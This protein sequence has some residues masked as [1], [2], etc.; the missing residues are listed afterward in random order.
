MPLG[1]AVPHLRQKRTTMALILQNDAVDAGAQAT[2]GV[3]LV[4][5]RD[6]LR[7]CQQRNLDPRNGQFGGAQRRETWVA[8]SSGLGVGADIGGERL[9]RLQ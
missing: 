9:P 7:C 3:I 1:Q 4:G 2:D 8:K 5:E 6:R